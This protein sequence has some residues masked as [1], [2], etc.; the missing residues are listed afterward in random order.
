MQPDPSAGM[1]ARIRNLTPSTPLFPGMDAAGFDHRI[2]EFQQRIQDR[3]VFPG[4]L[5][6][7]RASNTIPWVQVLFALLELGAKPLLLPENTID[8]E[9]ERISTSHGG[10]REIRLTATSEISMPPVAAPCGTSFGKNEASLFLSTSGTTGEPKLVER[11]LQSLVEE[12]RRYRDGIGLTPEDRILLPLPIYHAYGL[13]WLMTSLVSGTFIRLV[14]PTDLNAINHGLDTDP[15]TILVLTASLARILALRTRTS[16]NGHLRIAMVGAGPVDAPLEKTFEKRFGLKLSRNYGSTETG[17]IAAGLPPLPPYCVGRPL[18]GIRVRVRDAAGVPC[19]LGDGLLEVQVGDQAS[20]QP[21]GDIVNLDPQGLITIVGRNNESIRKGGRW[22]SP[23][24]IETVLKTCGDVLDVRLTKLPGRHVEDDKLRADILPM[25]YDSFDRNALVA[26]LEA[27]LS[28]HKRPDIIRAVRDLERTELGKTKQEPRY[29]LADSDTLLK[30]VIAYKQTEMVFALSQLGVLTYLDGRHDAFDIASFCGLDPDALKMLLSTA[31]ALEIV[32]T[33][34]GDETSD[35]LRKVQSFL[36]LEEAL[37]RTFVTRDTLTHILKNG[38]GQR[39]FEQDPLPE[40]MVDR[41]QNAIFNDAS[42]ARALLALRRLKPQDNWRFLEIS[43]G[44]GVYARL[45]SDRL[46]AIS[47]VLLHSGKLAGPPHEHLSER[48][49][50]IS[51]LTETIGLFDCCIVSNR[52]HGPWPGDDLRRLMDLVKPEGTLLVDDI[53][54]PRKGKVCAIA[55]DWLTHGGLNFWQYEAL[56][57]FCE[58]MGW[59]TSEQTIPGT[60][61]HRLVFINRP[62]CTT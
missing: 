18:P 16:A 19:D 56:E 15:A 26:E 30:A 39:R 4:E 37:S 46:P 60:D 24:E 27:K 58:K 9:L 51:D 31:A 13:A 36:D 10:L 21:F 41:Y 2:G 32:T 11:T 62:R 14:S 35:S 17:T 45:L 47:G 57:Q 33:P 43:N 34:A 6:A 20:W 40:G 22:V 29:Q 23:K 44:P 12:A 54:L 53:F 8:G 1:L 61:L 59:T 48:I 25:H 5:V 3:R 38:A 28:P 7:M 49:D 52:V 42:R 50:I 55:L